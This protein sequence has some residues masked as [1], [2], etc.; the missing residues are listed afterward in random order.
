M[1]M[2]CRT[3]LNRLTLGLYC[4]SIGKS[5]QYLALFIFKMTVRRITP[6]IELLRIT[7][8]DSTRSSITILLQLCL[9]YVNSLVN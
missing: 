6:K 9:L 7:P 8:L 1:E 5:F 3:V 2:S 4:I